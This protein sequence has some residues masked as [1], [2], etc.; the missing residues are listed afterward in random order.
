MTT[1]SLIV[2]AY[3]R[4]LA[5]GVRTALTAAATGGVGGNAPFPHIS[6]KQ[7]RW[8]LV[9]VEGEETIVKSF[10]IEFAV[11]AINPVVSKSFYI[12]AYS[13]GDD[14]TAPDC[15]S[16]DGRTPSVDADQPQSVNCATC[17]NNVWGSAVNP[18]NGKKLK[19]CKDAK[20]LSIMFLNEE[21]VQLAKPEIYSWRL[22]AMS[23]I[24]FSN[25]AK[26]VSG[27]GGALDFVVIRAE[28]DDTAEYP[29]VNYSVVRNMTE[30]EYNAV[31]AVRT[32]DEAKVSVGINDTPVAFVE[33]VAPVQQVKPRASVNP[34]EDPEVSQ[35]DDMAAAI[36]VETARQM[37]IAQ[38]RVNAKRVEA[39]NAEVATRRAAAAQA[40]K[41]LSD[42][43]TKA[44]AK[45]AFDAAVAAAVRAQMGTQADV[46]EDVP[47]SVTRP[48]R[49]EVK[50]TVTDVVEKPRQ[51]SAL[52]VV[53]PAA[54]SDDME[55]L[56]AAAL[57]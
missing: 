35:A 10:A 45:Q 14:A 24:N 2:P 32:S 34:S 12:K 46:F 37:A 27:N 52:N 33:R 43:A 49:T 55:D 53:K 50:F 25:F 39:E 44:A 54:A 29:L 1:T 15:Y 41:P 38:A 5:V 4:N 20:R 31:Q 6:I 40:Q 19:A 8:R 18:T 16:D 9:D 47:D 42:E 56:L 13:P 22:A 7:S 30:E 36:A 26:E 51:R 28:F 17:G 57:R 48:N 23:M 21:N 11:V 3:A